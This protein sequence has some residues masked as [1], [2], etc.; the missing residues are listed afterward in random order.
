MEDLELKHEDHFRSAYL[1]PAL[2]AG[3]I[4]MTIPDKHQSRLQRYRLTVL[5]ER[6]IKTVG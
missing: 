5:G 6:Q 2:D 1:T 4:E 3:Y